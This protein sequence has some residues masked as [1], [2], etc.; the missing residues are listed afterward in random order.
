MKLFFVFSTF[1][2]LTGIY[3]CQFAQSGKAQGKDSTKDSTVTDLE[4]VAKNLYLD[5]HHIGPGKVN[6][7]AVA[8][9]HLK[10]LVVEKKYGVHFIKFW[11]DE[12]DGTVYCL[13]SSPD[14][15]SISKAHAEAHGLM[16]DQV[17]EVT[18]GQESPLIDEQNFFLDVHELGKGKVTAKDVAAAHQ[19][20]LAVQQK[21]GVNFVNYWVN[22]AEGR[23]VCL[24][25]APDSFAIIKAH[26]EAHGLIPSQIVKV[27]QGE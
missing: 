26:T 6:Y 3:S 18:G 13:A 10:D 1:V 21:Y 12:V 22:E 24:S 23:V 15:Q 14:S 27:K 16:P 11:V 8:G 20:D 25:Q 2:I 5:A 19:K 7:A 4:P 17:Y 9:A